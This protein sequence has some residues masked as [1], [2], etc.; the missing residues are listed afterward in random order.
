MFS[1]AANSLCSIYWLFTEL[2]AREEIEIQRYRTLL[3]NEKQKV[4]ELELYRNATDK[5]DLE[6]LLDSTRGEK[7][8]LEERYTNAQEEIAVANNQLSTL[9]EHVQR[10]EE[11][12]KVRKQA[13]VCGVCLFD[14]RE[15]LVYQFVLSSNNI[16]VMVYQI[17]IEYW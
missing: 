10:L 5:S 1:Y 12:V 9:R 4:S 11:E 6:E 3:D 15:V 14:N 8:R 16:N 17:F 7:E 2:V 13:D